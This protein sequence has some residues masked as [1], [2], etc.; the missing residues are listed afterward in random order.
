MDQVAAHDASFDNEAET[1][2][3]NV[4]NQAKDSTELGDSAKTVQKHIDRKWR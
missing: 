3:I 4:N 1:I 2:E